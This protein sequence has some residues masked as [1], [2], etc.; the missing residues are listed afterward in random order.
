MRL[1]WRDGVATVLA[2]LGG[3]VAV[4]VL[5]EWDWPLLGSYGAGT[6][7]LGMIGLA[8]C[9]IGGYGFWNAVTARPGSTLRDGFLIVGVL[10]GLSVTTVLVIGLITSTRTPFVWMVVLMA[11]LWVEA[12]TRH[13]VEVA[14]GRTPPVIRTA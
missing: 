4:A 5:Q 10:L 13:A 8:M 11:T 3:V 6:L 2:V 1:T 14:P 9:G 7:A 12:T